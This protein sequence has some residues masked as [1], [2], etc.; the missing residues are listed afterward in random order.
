MAR[1]GGDP[2]MRS[3]AMRFTIVRI[4]GIGIAMAAMASCMPVERNT[5][6]VARVTF[7]TVDMQPV[8]I[9]EYTRADPEEATERGTVGGAIGGIMGAGIGATASMIPA[10]GAGIAGPAGAAVGIV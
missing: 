4:A 9:P 2:G 6:Q 10:L 5:V 8:A 1:A 3:C 7:D